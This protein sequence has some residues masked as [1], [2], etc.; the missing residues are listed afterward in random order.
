VPDPF[1]GSH[2]ASFPLDFSIPYVT[3]L[4]SLKLG[5]F[6]NPFGTISFN[7]HWF[8]FFDPS[9]SFPLRVFPPHGSLV[10]FSIIASAFWVFFLHRIIT[11]N[12]RVFRLNISDQ[13]RRCSV[14][15]PVGYPLAIA[16]SSRSL[17]NH[18]RPPQ[19]KLFSPSGR[20]RFDHRLRNDPALSIAI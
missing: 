4:S 9:I 1:L 13:P 5:G 6:K 2:D 10:T 16:L 11:R 17:S 14:Q 20:L 12:I 8:S 7:S 3:S 18:V 15:C 19:E